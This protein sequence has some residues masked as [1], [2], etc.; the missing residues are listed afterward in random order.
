LDAADARAE[1]QKL[2]AELSDRLSTPCFAQFAISLVAALLVAGAAA[3]LFWDSARVPY[4]GILAALASV[5]LALWS[6]SRYR[7]GMAFLRSELER[8]ERM[9]GL[10]RALG[11]DDPTALLPE[12]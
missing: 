12:T 6:V 1:L 5:F 10:R 4:L 11:L 9:Q 8:F 7:R 2:E 3:K